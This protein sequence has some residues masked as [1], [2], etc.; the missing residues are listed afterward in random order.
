[1][2]DAINPSH[3]RS[4]PSG[5]EC[6][7]IT[8]HLSFNRGNAVKYLWRSGKKDGNSTNQEL[9]KAIWY[10]TDETENNDSNGALNYSANVIRD[11]LT[12]LAIYDLDEYVTLLR[13]I[14]LGNNNSLKIAIESIKSLLVDE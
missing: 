12:K 1:M 3:Y 6:I 8:R 11:K 10:L 13:R 2:N 4:H 9:G 14:C 7:E 5:I